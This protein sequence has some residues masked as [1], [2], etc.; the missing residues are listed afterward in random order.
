MSLIAALHL[1][2][3]LVK[4]AIY[5]ILFSTFAPYTVKSS[6]MIYQLLYLLFLSSYRATGDSLAGDSLAG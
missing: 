1:H 5:D 4:S 3:D 2:Y 6:F